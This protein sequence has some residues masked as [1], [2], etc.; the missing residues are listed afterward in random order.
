MSFEKPLARYSAVFLAFWLASPW[1]APEMAMAAEKA[2]PRRGKAYF[3]IVCQHCHTTA[4]ATTE[5]KSRTTEEWVL[6]FTTDRHGPQGD[7]VRRYMG[8]AYRS[9]IKA[10]NRD[11]T[12]ILPWQDE[13]VFQDVRAFFM[14]NASDFDGPDPCQ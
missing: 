9:Q 13:T 10:T 3:Q 4:T 2:S 8:Q 14:K 6:Y 5:P 12:P 7:S 11:V 1:P